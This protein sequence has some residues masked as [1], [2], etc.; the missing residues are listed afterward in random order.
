MAVKKLKVPSSGDL[1]KKYADSYTVI[2][3]EDELAKLPKLPCRNL[4]L[5]Y[6]LGGG[7][8]YGKV[9][10]IFGYESTGKTLMAYDFGYA[11][12][13][14]GGVLLIIDAENAFEIGWAKKNGLDPARTVILPSNEIEM[15]SDWVRDQTYYWRDKLVNNE[16][17]VVIGDSIAFFECSDNIESDAVGAKAEMGNRAKAI[18]KFYRTRTRL[19]KRAGVCV[20]MINQVR[21]KIGASMFESAETTPGGDSTR[22]AASIRISLTRST[23]IKGR[24]ID[25]E[26]K[27]DDKGHKIGQHIIMRMEKNKVAPPRPSIK[28][29]V[30]FLDEKWGYTGY[31]RYKGLEEILVDQGVVKNVGSRYYYK[32]KMIANGV[33]NFIKALHKKPKLRGNLIRRSSINTI[34]KTQDLLN[35]LDRNLYRL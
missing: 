8:P 9:I 32:E 24:I 10:E 29:E 19:F 30:Y 12:Q 18:G 27:E 28:T 15:A 16:P 13:Q 1:A 26:F 5:N 11:A 17:I 2:E 4:A 6:M 3:M 7:I 33:D 31:N 34:S 25:G 22:F 23:Q 20:I 14:L 35:S 21:K